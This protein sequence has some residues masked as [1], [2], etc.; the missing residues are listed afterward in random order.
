[1]EYISLIATIIKKAPKHFFNILTSVY[2]D[3]LEPIIAPKI[4]NIDIIIANF[5]SIFLF[6]IFIIIA[7]IE[8]G[9]SDLIYQENYTI[10]NNGTQ[11]KSK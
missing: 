6:F 2:T 7:T 4:P 10:N 3:I 9:I 1:M 8:V 5:K 11:I